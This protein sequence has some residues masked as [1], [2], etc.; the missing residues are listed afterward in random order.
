MCHV[1]SVFK[2]MQMFSYKLYTL[3][4]TNLYIYVFMAETFEIMFSCSLSCIH[5]APEMK[6]HHT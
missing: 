1:M 6:D 5:F 4:L 2:T 3:K